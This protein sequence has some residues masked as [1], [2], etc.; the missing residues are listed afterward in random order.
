[1]LAIVIVP[2]IIIRQSVLVRSLDSAL[3]MVFLGSSV[4]TYFSIM[5]AENLEQLASGGKV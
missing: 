2:I 5:L 3:F 1:M 4:V